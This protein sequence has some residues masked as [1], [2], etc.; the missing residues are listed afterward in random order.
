MVNRSNRL[1][2]QGIQQRNGKK[3][4]YF[5]TEGFRNERFLPYSSQ[6]SRYPFKSSLRSGLFVL[7]GLGTKYGK[8]LGLI[9]PQIVVLTRVTKRDCSGSS[10]FFIGTITESPTNI[11][12]C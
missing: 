3:E 12:Q 7:S 6:Q 8:I 5:T 2:V 11:K 9:Q 1:T 10:R 4:S